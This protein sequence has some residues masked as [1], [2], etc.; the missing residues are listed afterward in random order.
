MRRLWRNFLALIDTN[1]DW[2]PGRLA[3]VV[4]VPIAILLTPPA[5]FL[6]PGIRTDPA[7]Q[8]NLPNPDGT[9]AR[10]ALEGGGRQPAREIQIKSESVDT[11][12]APLP[13]F[14]S[15]DVTLRRGDTLLNVL[16]RH[17]LD[18]TS[19]H[20]LIEKVRPFFNPRKMREGENLQLMLD[21]QT[22]AVRGLEYI[23]KSMLVRVMSSSDG[24]SA[25]RTDI[26]FVRETK[27]LRGSINDNLYLGGTA[28]GLSPQQ[29][30]ELATIFEYDVDFFSDFRR[31]DVFAVALEE[32]RYADGR[33]EAGN[34]L[35]AELEA[36]KEPFRAFYYVGK[37][38][39]GDYYDS[40]G[41]AM[42]RA[43][44]RAPLS[45][46]RISSSYNLNRRH[47]ISRTVR[48]H[49]AIDYAAPAGTPVVAIGHG[50]VTFTGWQGGYGNLVEVRHP[51]GY[52]TRYAHF[53]RIASGI[54]RGRQVNQGQVVGY[55]GQTGHAT[56]PH[57]HFE[58]LRRGEKINF[59]ALRIPKLE[60]L[61]G[62]D[63]EQFASLRES[64]MALLQ[65]DGVEVAR[66]E[67]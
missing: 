31:G 60:Q 61:R 25:E 7:N 35:A 1:S 45:Y 56:G 58:M 48:P 11:Q 5:I 23:L 14:R 46:R 26:P 19:A 2:N 20:S 34:I 65:Q 16:T 33:R 6:K 36:D 42:R 9:A 44:L 3:V 52:T 53:T 10:K 30:L 4:V 41:R 43:F 63:L 40:D 38:G 66:K 57:L 54:R 59:L 27:I 18:L 55:V 64:R 28:A 32:I 67:P 49:R 29:I 37:D 39:K 8:K 21:P 13:T 47:P 51:N 17:G 22:S 62:A 12:S 15:I 50:R 24:W